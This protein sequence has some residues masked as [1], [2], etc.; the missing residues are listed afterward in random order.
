MTVFGPVVRPSTHFPT[1]QISQFAHGGKVGSE[2]IRD[3]SLSLAVDL[4]RMYAG[5][6]RGARRDTLL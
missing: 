1:I 5:Y 3:D 6:H 2:P 4:R